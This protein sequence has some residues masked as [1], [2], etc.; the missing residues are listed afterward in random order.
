[1]QS[2]SQYRVR[3]EHCGRLFIFHDIQKCVGWKNCYVWVRVTS[4][5]T[6][7]IC[8]GLPHE[9]IGTY[10]VS[11][12]ELRHSSGKG[13]LLYYL[14]TLG[15]FM[16]GKVL[17]M[18]FVMKCAMCTS[19]VYRACF[20]DVRSISSQS[21]V[22]VR[23]RSYQ[24]CSSRHLDI[25]YTIYWEMLEWTGA[26]CINTFVI[27]CGSKI[28]IAIVYIVAT[29]SRNAAIICSDSA[30]S[31]TLIYSSGVKVDAGLPL[32]WCP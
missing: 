31:L 11:S 17:L 7:S 20:N 6:L 4:S 5:T 21:A 2:M 13:W 22:W 14:V 25:L 29:E 28:P 15:F 16:A 30:F 19:F 8:R 1:M 10:V 32:F 18:H 23:F 24:C 3:F 9:Y 26:L 27:P 12:L